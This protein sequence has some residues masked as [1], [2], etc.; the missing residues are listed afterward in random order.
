[1][2]DL[3]LAHLTAG[4]EQRRVVPGVGER[5]RAGPRVIDQVGAAGHRRVELAGRIR[6]DRAQRPAPV[7]ELAHDLRGRL[8]VLGEGAQRGPQLAH[9]R[10][11]PGAAPLH[12]A[13][14]DADPP[15]RQRD[16]V[17]PVAA[18][19]GLDPL[20]VGLQRLGGHVPAGDLEA[21]EGG[22]ALRQQAGLERQ[23]GAPLLLE[24]HRVIDGD[25]D[26][27][28]DRRHEATVV[29]VV[30]PLPGR[31]AGTAPGSS[32]RAARRGRTAG[33]RRP[34]RPRPAPGP[35]GSGR[36][37]PGTAGRAGPAPPP[38]PAAPSPAGRSAPPGSG[39]A[40]PPGPASRRRRPAA[41]VALRPADQLVALEQVD[42]AVVGELGDQRLGHVPQRDVE[43]ERAGQALADPL[44]QR[45]PVAFAPAAAPGGLAGDDHDPLD[46]AG[47]IAQRDGLGP[48]EDPGPVG[49]RAGEGA[50]PGAARQHLPGQLGRGAG[51]PRLWPGSPGAPPGPPSPHMSERTD[52]PASRPGRPGGRTGRPRRRSRT[53]GG[54]AGR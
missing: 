45:D 37:A 4:D 48:D 36:S 42:E 26:P 6:R 49:P 30:V 19:L 28:G 43:L 53:A 35:A 52:S 12:V 39:P 34:R 17:V 3:Q 50:L 40:R 11:R 47:G 22:Q 1:M 20:P 2:L 5:Q 23:R 31:S 25:G 29:G 14:D 24:Q 8:V 15:R 9:D 13:D 54:R 7:V 41:G 51:I 38:C 46:R 21:V 16:Q 32:R 27:A 44:Q 18:H 33:R 10:G